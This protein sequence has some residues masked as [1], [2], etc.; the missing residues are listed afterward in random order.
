MSDGQVCGVGAACENTCPVM[1]FGRICP[2]LP[3]F[4]QEVTAMTV[5]APQLA[6]QPA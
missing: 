6:P 3:E 2:T 1:R 5:E 4:I